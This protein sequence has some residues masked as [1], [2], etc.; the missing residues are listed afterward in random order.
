MERKKHKKRHTHTYIYDIAI[1]ANR[2]NGWQVKK[3]YCEI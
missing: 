2:R 1:Y 3:K